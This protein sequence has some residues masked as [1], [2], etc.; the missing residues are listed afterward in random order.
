MKASVSKPETN[1]RNCSFHP[2][3]DFLKKI[4]YSKRWNVPPPTHKTVLIPFHWRKIVKK[5]K[6][7]KMRYLNKHVFGRQARPLKLK[8]LRLGSFLGLG[9][10]FYLLI[11]TRNNY[12]VKDVCSFVHE[13]YSLVGRKSHLKSSCFFLK[14]LSEI[15]FEESLVPP[16]PK[17]PESKSC[18]LACD[19]T[20]GPFDWLALN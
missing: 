12:I 1:Q 8:W 9:L 7:K 3:L 15:A 11:N 4:N 14:P 17:G 13:T 2:G 10:E 20:V 18:K 16:L 5:K 19:V 6:W